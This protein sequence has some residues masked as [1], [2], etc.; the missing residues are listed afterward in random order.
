[1]TR[2][3]QR[4][5]EPKL[6]TRTAREKLAP[7]GK[8]Y[9]RSLS[10]GLHI[11]YRKGRKAARGVVRVY[12]GNARYVVETLAS[13]DDRAEANGHDILTFGQAIR[14]A[15][16]ARSRLNANLRQ[17]GPYT[18]SNALEDYF[19]HLEQEAKATSD[20]R[21]RAKVHISPSLGSVVVAKLT[22]EKLR[23]WLKELADAPA[24]VRSPASAEGPVFR[25]LNG[26]DYKRQRRS[27]A[28]RTFTVLKA[29]LNLA[30]REGRV[31]EDKA[32][33]SVKPFAAVEAARVRYLQ[34]DEARRLINASRPD[35]RVLVQAAL[36][37]G[38]RY[39]ELRALKVCDFNRDT[40]TVSIRR[41]KSGRAR[42]VV[43]TD[44]GS[45]FFDSVCTGRGAAEVMIQ[46]RGRLSR[47]EAAFQRRAEAK[48][49][50]QA[51]TRDDGA[52]RPSEQ[53]RAMRDVSNDARISPPIN[54]HAL[55][56]T[57][58]SHSVMAGVPLLIVARNLGHADT[59]MVEKHYGHLA[60]SYITDAIRKGAPTFGV[61]HNSNLHPIKAAK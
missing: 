53:A 15:E 45:A 29:A 39:G 33:R 32:W 22:P 30:W 41:S 43:L 55:R 13:A 5:R 50:Q 11:G 14:A 21:N 9:Y 23:S 2:L 3:A 4:T 58:A 35:F 40:G 60:P 25:Q 36:H 37:T 12:I 28:N 54:F 19:W 38:C 26:E 6:D 7:S 46:N 1:M 57:W 18:V 8:P 56:H 47:A 61:P 44:E 59:R 52:W 24:Q 51:G 20:S 31:A 34:I 10:Q 27:S 48:H 49:E 16:A 17:S 42:H